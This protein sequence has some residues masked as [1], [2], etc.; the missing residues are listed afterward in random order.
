MRS[1]W[2]VAA[3]LLCSMAASPVLADESAADQPALE[4]DDE[5]ILY[6]L[7]LAIS[8]NLA[9]FEFSEAELSLVQAGMADGVMGREP[10]VAP[11]VYGP[12]IDPMLQ[13]R[14]AQLVENEKQAGQAF[15]EQA[16]QEPGAE[17]TES[18]MVYLEMEPGDGASPAATDSVRVHYHGT[19]RDG[20]VFDTSLEGDNPMPATFSLNGVIACFSEGIQ[21]MK[22]GGKSKL[23]C[24]P[25]LAYGD[26]GSPPGIKPGA[27]LQFEVQLIEIV[28]PPPAAETPAPESAPDPAPAP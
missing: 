20:T 3:L 21:K 27:T 19:L 5:K 11:E 2:I 22:V 6:T 15:R 1:R 24:P 12:Q 26:R 14:M 25:E 10:R 7:G 23:T 8:R 16:G 17:T 13:A 28:A 9:L 4:T 18:G